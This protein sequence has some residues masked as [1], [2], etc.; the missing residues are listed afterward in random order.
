MGTQGPGCREGRP[1]RSLA[2]SLWADVANAPDV[3]HGLDSSLEASACSGFFQAG[4]AVA[5]YL[6]FPLIFDS[7]RIKDLEG[8]LHSVQLTKKKEEETFRRK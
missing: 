6:L 5:P 8:K 7:F 2:I 1:V 4:F 3:L